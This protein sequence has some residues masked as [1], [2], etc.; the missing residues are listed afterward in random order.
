MIHVLLMF[1]VKKFE[2]I[3]NFG[4][5]FYKYGD[6]ATQILEIATVCILVVEGFRLMFSVF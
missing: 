5:V 4:N 2:K 1:I 6:H 3:M